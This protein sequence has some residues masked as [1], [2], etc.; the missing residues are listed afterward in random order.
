METTVRDD[1]FYYLTE[2]RA[3]RAPI[4]PRYMHNKGFY[5][6]SLSKLSRWMGAIAEELMERFKE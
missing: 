5:I 6:V 2:N 4:T 3:F 1:E